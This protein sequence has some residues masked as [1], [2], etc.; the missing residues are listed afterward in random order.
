MGQFRRTYRST[1]F[2]AAIAG[3]LATGSA[4]QANVDGW[5]PLKFGMTLD[6]ALAAVNIRWDQ[7]GI[8][9]CRTNAAQV[10][11]ELRAPNM[12]VPM[13]KL[14]FQ[15]AIMFDT[16]GRLTE[17]GL[18]YRGSELTCVNLYTTVLDELEG[19]YGLFS[20]VQPPSAGT[21]FD[22]GTGPGANRGTTLYWANL[23]TDPAARAS[24]APLRP[25]VGLDMLGS[26]G[27]EKAC[28]IYIQYRA[29]LLPAL[30]VV[31]APVAQPPAVSAAPPVQ[32]SVPQTVV[33]PTPP[34]PPPAPV[35]D[36]LPA[37]APVEETAPTAPPVVPETAVASLAPPV[38]EPAPPPAPAP[39]PR[40]AWPPPPQIDG[41]GALKFGMLLDDALA[42]TDI[43]WE[44][45]T[46]TKCRENMARNGCMIS[47]RYSPEYQ[48]TI[49]GMGFEPAM[50]FDRWGR[51]TAF[52]LTFFEDVWG[53]ED[54]FVRTLDNLEARYGALR[55][56]DPPPEGERYI[57]GTFRA[58]DGTEV[59]YAD[60]S[61]DPEAWQGRQ[62]LRS[63]VSARVSGPV[64]GSKGCSVTVS[65][66]SANL[67]PIAP[68]PGSVTF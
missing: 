53:C 57:K 24:E 8:D 10:G 66:T 56:E 22:V 13:A 50:S 39:A 30:A 31:E 34:A 25:L 46:L 23:S 21:R 52:S 4:A 59:F 35:A 37:P 41:W 32:S 38:P 36:P 27:A 11:C 29:G 62:V 7:A 5:G 1:F 43:P 6:Q 28:T 33:Q 49:D 67:P 45:F 44:T 17:I 16:S 26:V 42:A 58:D 60:L 20:G 68:P 14:N 65:Y 47:S 12:Q 18:E 54:Y 63:L 48:I 9:A 3:S 61:T 40:S 15:P 51:L 2:V 19:Q 64:S 55:Q